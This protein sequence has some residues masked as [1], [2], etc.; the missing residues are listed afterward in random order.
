[1]TS[2]LPDAAPANW[3]D[4]HAPAALRPWLR[5]GRFD[6][7]TGIWLLMLPG[8]QGVALAAAMQR[9]WPSPRLLALIFLGAA[10]MRAAGCAYNDIVDRDIDAQVS[11]TAGRPIPSGQISVKQAL[12]FVAGCSLVSLLILL[13]MGPLAIGLGVASLAL[14]AAYPFMKRITWWPQAW[15]GLTFN[16]GA[17]LGFAAAT[18]TLTWQAALLYAGGVFWT[19]G[20]DT[21]YAL[22]DLEDD[23]LA[24]VKSTARRLGDKVPRAVTAFYGLAL[25]FAFAAG[26][27][28]GLGLGF[29]VVLLAYAV[30]LAMQARQVRVHD[31]VLALKLFKS[32]GLA[33]FTLVV[34]LALGAIR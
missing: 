4:R 12:A 17:L 10:L 7:P 15:L 25:M 21:I 24:G 20:Y 34:A 32:N 11:R 26:W 22:Q 1:M 13:T 19:L 30:Q 3:V 31:P 14:V 33:G 28:G 16:W 29:S 27:T 23:A 8:W 5:L 9:M 2:P 18:G 6:R